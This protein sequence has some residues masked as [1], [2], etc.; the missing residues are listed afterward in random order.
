MNHWEGGQE[1][2]MEDSHCSLDLCVLG[3]FMKTSQAELEPKPFNP[4]SALL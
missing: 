4:F 3:F 2:Q 1:G